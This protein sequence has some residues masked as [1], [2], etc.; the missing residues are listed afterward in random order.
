MIGTVRS[1]AAGDKSPP[2]EHAERC[3]FPAM[4]QRDRGGR[5]RPPRQAATCA[6]LCGDQSTGIEAARALPTQ[7]LCSTLTL[8]A[9]RRA[10]VSAI[11]AA[12]RVSASGRADERFGSSNV[13][14]A[15]TRP[16]RS[17]PT[18]RRPITSST[19]P[20]G[21]KPCHL[22]RLSGLAPIR[23]YAGSSRYRSRPRACADRRRVGAVPRSRSRPGPPMTYR[24]ASRRHDRRSRS[25]ATQA[26][27][28]ATPRQRSARAPQETVSGRA[29]PP[30][31]APKRR[32]EARRQLGQPLGRRG[33]RRA[34]G[35][36]ARQTW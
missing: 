8:Q 23:P 21:L 10:S 25:R 5:L 24:R 27:G 29:L 32:E 22:W 3:S 30:T 6:G 31:A 9:A 28:R 34:T 20:D 4:R 11:C 1:W 13:W 26:R 19:R 7:R 12:R 14:F 2:I 17:T 36:T 15:S 16:I 18:R 33:S 35:S